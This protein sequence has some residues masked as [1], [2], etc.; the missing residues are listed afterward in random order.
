M[1]NDEKAK[2]LSAESK[3]YDFDGNKG[4]SH[5]IRLSIGGEIFSVKSTEEQVNEFK[6]YVGQEGQ[7]VVSFSSPKENLKMTI[8]SFKPE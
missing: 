7:V 2:V 8:D 3:P 6:K 1:K 5:K 4:T